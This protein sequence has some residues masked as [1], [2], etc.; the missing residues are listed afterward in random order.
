MP[1]YTTVAAKIFCLSPCRFPGGSGYD[2][3]ELHYGVG[4]Y[5]QCFT[6]YVFSLKGAESVG[7]SKPGMYPET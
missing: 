3:L 7:G 5:Q 6:I 2:V 1:Y 4:D